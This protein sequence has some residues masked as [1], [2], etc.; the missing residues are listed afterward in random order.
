MYVVSLSSVHEEGI[1]VSFVMSAVEHRLTFF[2]SFSSVIAVA[3]TKQLHCQ[4]SHFLTI[5][6]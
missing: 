4:A 6:R 3:I 1:D 2:L 5:T